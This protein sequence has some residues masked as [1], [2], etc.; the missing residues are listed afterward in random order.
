[1][2]SPRQY[3]E[4]TAVSYNA[5][6]SRI[7][8]VCSLIFAERKR[9]IFEMF[10]PVQGRF[11]DVGCGPGPFADRLSKWDVS[12]YG[13]DA[14]ST[15]IQLA[16]R[17]GYRN[18]TFLVGLVERIPFLDGQFD[19]VL[20]SGVLEYVD[21]AEES[22]REIA[23]VSKR[24]AQVVVTFPH[25]ESWT[26]QLDA[27]LRAVIRFLR[28]RLRI[29]GAGRL[30]NPDYVPRYPASSL[31]RRLLVRYGFVIE[32]NRYHFFRLTPLNKLCPPLS[33]WLSRR[34][35]F[36]RSRRWSANALVRARKV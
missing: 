28:D 11:L 6:Y 25:G 5:A 1:M 29:P 31:I 17:R 22:I 4:E 26:N 15:M 9:L 23:R 13:V 32:E 12:V 21:S 16:K 3:F 35:N 24:G 36:I 7:D 20:A 18:F 2:K 30:I 27:A 10:V 34:L 8:S 33:L 14:S 19:G